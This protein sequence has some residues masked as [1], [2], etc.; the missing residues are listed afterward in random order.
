MAGGGSSAASAS[1]LVPLPVVV[2]SVTIRVL[3]ALRLDDPKGRGAGLYALPRDESLPPPPRWGPGKTNASSGIERRPEGEGALDEGRDGGRDGGREPGRETEGVPVVRA[4]RR[5]LARARS[6][7]VPPARK[8]TGSVSLSASIA[9]CLSQL[10]GLGKGWE[11]M[12]WEAI[13]K[14]QSCRSLCYSRDSVGNSFPSN[15]SS[16]LRTHKL[17][18]DGRMADNQQD[19]DGNPPQ[20]V[21]QNVSKRVTKPHAT[22][23]LSF[24]PSS[25]T[26]H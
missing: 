22:H 21:S 6:C 18:S 14:S 10:M 12:D 1:S 15:D 7:S 2:P 25:S 8:T 23:P 11:A 24:V 17:R 3:L 13:R 5:R 19:E 16:R 26:K 20:T 4:T 9:M